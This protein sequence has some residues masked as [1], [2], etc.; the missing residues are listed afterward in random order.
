MPE[1]IYNENSWNTFSMA[2]KFK[3]IR[4]IL[5]FIRAFEIF[6]KVV[7]KIWKSF[8]R[9]GITMEFYQPEY[10]REL[11]VTNHSFGAI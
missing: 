5:L 9:G 1:I 6:V 11:W 10:S 7:P 4:K 3:L 2:I 8:I